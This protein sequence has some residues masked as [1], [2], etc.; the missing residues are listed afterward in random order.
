MRT[1]CDGFT[2][3]FPDRISEQV[4]QQFCLVFQFR[5]SVGRI[6][7]VFTIGISED[8]QTVPAV[9][10][11]TPGLES[12]GENNLEVGLTGFPV[13]TGHRNVPCH[14]LVQEK[15]KFQVVGSKVDHGDAGKN[16]SQGI[17]QIGK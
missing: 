9:H 17:G 13:P 15:G 8:V 3:A 16:G 11:K 12:G 7:E 1:W 4:I 5:G 6:H 10:K 14:R 2:V